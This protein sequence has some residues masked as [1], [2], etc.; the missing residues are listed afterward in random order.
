[1]HIPR[2]G[3]AMSEDILAQA[4]KLC[5]KPSGYEI[6]CKDGMYILSG[7]NQIDLSKAEAPPKPRPC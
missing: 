5:R 1:M 6:E 7:Y 4:E 2:D 3:D